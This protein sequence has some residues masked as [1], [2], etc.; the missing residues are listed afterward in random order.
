M[1]DV[2]VSANVDTM[3]KAANNAA[4]RTAI[5]LGS[6]DNTSDASKPIS[7]AQAINNVT[8]NRKQIELIG[9]IG[10]S[11]TSPTRYDAWHNSLCSYLPNV[12]QVDNQAAGGA[13]AH[14]ATGTGGLAQVAALNA[15]CNTVFVLFGTNDA[16]AAKSTAT[17]L[18]DILALIVAIRARGMRPVV[19]AP[20][21]SDDATIA[22][23]TRAYAIALRF[24]CEANSVEYLDSFSQLIDTDGSWKVGAN[25]SGD[26]DHI[27]TAS[28]ITCAKDASS[29]YQGATNRLL[30]RNNVSSGLNPNA[31]QLLDSEYVAGLANGWWGFD[32]ATFAMSTWAWPG[33]G[34][35]C[36]TSP[37]H[38]SESVFTE[39]YLRMYGVSPG[40][41]IRVTGLISFTSIVNCYC[42][43]YLRTYGG[44]APD[45]PIL[46]LFEAT[47]EQYCSGEMTM[48]TGATA[49]DLYIKMAPLAA[50]AHSC[51]LSFGA[52]SGYKI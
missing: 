7:T 15:N 11:F 52:F 47:N 30:P 9:F 12:V 25:V 49:I 1:A 31:L 18:A 20:Q 39:Q 50:G 21:T 19:M 46:S 34:R 44:T 51:T 24:M 3:L 2:T 37:S 14:G 43:V 5:G 41:R 4:I 8:F 28:M 33:L 23:R 32:M 45:K 6:V 27:T 29:Q 26:P 35:K 13:Q 36:T 42:Y 22:G 40:D 10:D 17:F 38:A 48:P 16:Y